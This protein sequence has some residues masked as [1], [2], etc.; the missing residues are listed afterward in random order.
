ML[1]LN[2]KIE[3]MEGPTKHHV[4]PLE[5]HDALSTDWPVC[6]TELKSG[7]KDHSEWGLRVN[8]QVNKGVKC[9]LLRNDM[10]RHILTSPY[11]YNCAPNSESMYSVHALQLRDSLLHSHSDT[12]THFNKSFFFLFH[13]NCYLSS[14]PIHSTLS[15]HLFHP[16][17][18]AA[19]LAMSPNKPWFEHNTF[20]TYLFAQLLRS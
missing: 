18:H 15:V 14:H 3:S 13:P 9:R 19:V 7:I 11:D 20:T 1:E 6:H 4:K 2:L 10:Y 5:I 12:L 8:M 16:S 17:F